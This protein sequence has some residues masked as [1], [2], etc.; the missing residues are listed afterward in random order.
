MAYANR[1]PRQRG[2]IPFGGRSV[3]AAPNGTVLA[4][5][6]ANDTELIRCIIDRNNPSYVKAQEANPYLED[7]IPELY[8]STATD[9]PS[10]SMIGH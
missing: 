10:Q 7:R 5:A 6:G 3:V 9:E 8:L 4:Q 2:D 1:V